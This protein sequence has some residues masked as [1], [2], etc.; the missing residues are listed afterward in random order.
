[1]VGG[2]KLPFLGVVREADC[3]EWWGKSRP[4]CLTSRAGKSSLENT[5]LTNIIACHAKR[6]EKEWASNE[7]A[8]CAT[9]V[10]AGSY[11]VPESQD[12]SEERA[13]EQNFTTWG[14]ER[15]E[16]K[17]VVCCCLS[18]YGGLS[19]SLGVSEHPMLWTMQYT[20]CRKWCLKNLMKFGVL[21]VRIRPHGYLF[22]QFSGIVLSSRTSSF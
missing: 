19:S 1:M 13:I 9:C 11:G 7:E 14:R 12:R 21:V 16:F 17:V 8:A 4:R 2:G 3:E 22:R 6:L 5:V 15:A 20:L 10:G 18:F